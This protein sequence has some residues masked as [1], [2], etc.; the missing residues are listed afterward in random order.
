MKNKERSFID[1]RSDAL[2]VVAVSSGKTGAWMLLRNYYG[3]NAKPPPAFDDLIE[4]D[5]TLNETIKIKKAS[6]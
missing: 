2:N 5:S 4:V 1:S 3:E 6:Q